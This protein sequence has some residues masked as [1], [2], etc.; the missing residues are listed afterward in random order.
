MLQTRVEPF[1]P[2][3]AINIAGQ[4]QIFVEKCRTWKAVRN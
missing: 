1:V 3:V 2:F 4:Q